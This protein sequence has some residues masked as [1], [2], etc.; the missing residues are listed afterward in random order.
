M[1]WLERVR[2]WVQS[3]RAVHRQL[4]PAAEPVRGGYRG[5]GGGGGYR[6]GG[7]GGGFGGM[8]LTTRWVLGGLFVTMLGFGGCCGLGGW[9]AQNTEA[10][11]ATDGKGESRHGRS[12]RKTRTVAVSAE[13]LLQEFQTDP[14][15]ADKKYQGEVS[16]DFRRRGTRGAE[17]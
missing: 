7:G 12:Q 9:R 16:G 1:L 15:A 13:Q 11:S 14:D 17:E 5:S 8:S 4:P 2:L 10:P 3:H 6:G